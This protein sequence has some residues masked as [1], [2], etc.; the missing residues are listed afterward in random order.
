MRGVVM[1]VWNLPSDF[2]KLE[3]YPVNDLHVGDPLS[4]TKLFKQFIKYVLDSPDR[5]L[6]Y[7]GD[8]MNNAI[9]SSVSNTY[10]EIM[11]PD[12]QKDWLIDELY[13]VR[14]RFLCFVPGNHE[15]RTARESDVSLVKDIARALGKKHLYKK[16]EAFIKLTL[17]KNRN[18]KR[19]SYH[20]WAV[21]GS[22]GGGT[23]GTVLNRMYKAT[24]LVEGVDIYIQ[25]HAHQKIGYKFSKRVFD[26][27]NQT[28]RYVPMLAACAASW[29]QYGGYAANKQLIPGVVEKTPIILSGT[30]KRFKVEI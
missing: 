4:N 19:V 29:L 5:Y 16:D 10:K 22:G 3:L 24:T 14:D 15:E 7:I 27:Y 13:P 26:P 23:P 25:G 30:D 28:I 2:E 21:H 20:I 8:N 17:G 11:S 18:N 6:M 1:L 12:E 9:K